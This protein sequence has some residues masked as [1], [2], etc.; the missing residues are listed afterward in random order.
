MI[1]AH[2]FEDP[3]W[4]QNEFKQIESVSCLKT[5]PKFERPNIT[6]KFDDKHNIYIK[7][8]SELQCPNVSNI[9]IMGQHGLS[10]LKHDSYKDFRLE[11]R[12]CP[13]IADDCED[14]TEIDKYIPEI[15]V[16]YIIKTNQYLE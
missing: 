8:L 12:K 9:D 14:S 3:H 4:E 1:K 5:M 10:Q 16:D 2:K 6:H 7:M 13:D 11:F 15:Y